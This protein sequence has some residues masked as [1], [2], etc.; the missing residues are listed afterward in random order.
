MWVV[1]LDLNNYPQTVLS[2]F[3]DFFKKAMLDI[4]LYIIFWRSKFRI[5][6]LFLCF[7]IT[8]GKNE[9]EP[10]FVPKQVAELLK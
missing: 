6:I 2:F 5:I 7:S 8:T 3:R 10:V 9:I 4:G 1:A